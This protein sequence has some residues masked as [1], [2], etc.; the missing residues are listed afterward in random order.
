MFSQQVPPELKI[1][2]LNKPPATPQSVDEKTSKYI[3]DLLNQQN[4]GAASTSA[5]EATEHERPRKFVPPSEYEDYVEFVLFEHFIISKLSIREI[6][7]GAGGD[8]CDVHI[9]FKK[10]MPALP[11]TGVSCLS[12][13][14]LWKDQ[15]GL[16]GKKAAPAKLPFVK[17]VPY[18][19]G[20][21]EQKEVAWAGFRP[22]KGEVLTISLD[23]S[24]KMGIKVCTSIYILI[25][26][27]ENENCRM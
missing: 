22:R 25:T 21:S 12:P 16:Q 19:H 5:S 24:S 8:G 14:N 26:Q 6:C 15:A 4:N 10:G 20:C 17:L 7:S 2:L 1:P 13:D 3:N 27:N 18:K 11:Q 9:H 23:I